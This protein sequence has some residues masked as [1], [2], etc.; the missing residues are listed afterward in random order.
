MKIK[1]TFLIES[2]AEKLKSELSSHIKVTL[3]KNPLNKDKKWP[4][5]DKGIFVGVRVTFL[6]DGIACF[7]YVPSFLARMF[8]GGLI[9][10]VFYYQSRKELKQRIE[11]YLLSEFYE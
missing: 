10:G 7:T 8:F 3:R 4:D 9:S 1:D 6:P 5:I 2:A 11:S